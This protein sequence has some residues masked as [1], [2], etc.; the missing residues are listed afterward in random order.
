[1][2][3]R[4]DLGRK[5]GAA[6]HVRG[7]A[8]DLRRAFVTFAAFVAILAQTFIVQTHVDFASGETF[9]SATEQGAAGAPLQTE[10]R[11]ALN[12]GNDSQTPCV[13]CQ[14]LATAGAAVITALPAIITTHG[15]ATRASQVAIQ[16]VVVRSAHSWQS[17]AP[18]FSL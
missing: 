4:G 1:M 16:R 17:R 7:R 9:A 10:L 12:P 11:A 15:I 14:T 6:V 8:F 13:I 18:P 2:R 3:A 5:R